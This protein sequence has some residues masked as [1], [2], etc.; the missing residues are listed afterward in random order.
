MLHE[1]F[2]VQNWDGEESICG[3]KKFLTGEM[4]MELRREQWDAWYGAEHCMQQRHIWH[5]NTED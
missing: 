1:M 3:E 4:I 5:R 2:A